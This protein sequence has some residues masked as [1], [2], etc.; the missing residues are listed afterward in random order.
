VQ[1]ALLFL[2]QGLEVI[3]EVRLVLALSRLLVAVELV[4]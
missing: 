2:H 4:L 3:T 1:V